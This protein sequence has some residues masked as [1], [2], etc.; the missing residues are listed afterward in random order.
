MHIIKHLENATKPI[1]SYEIVPPLRGTT[2]IDAI[3]N[4]IEQVLPYDPKWINVTTHASSLLYVE[5]NDGTITKRV[6][7]KRPGTTGICGVIQNKYGIDAVAHMLCQGFSQ[8]ETEDA[9]IELNYM[10]I[11]NVL[12]LKGDNLNYK[13]I[14]NDHETINH[15]AIDLVSQIRDIRDGRFL[16]DTEYDPINF[17]TGVAGYPEKHFESA[18]ME[19]NI[20]YLK[21]KID[22]GADY[23]VT[24][25]FFDNNKYFNFVKQCRE[26]GINVPIIPG[27][28]VLKS[29]NQ[30]NTIP[31]MFYVDLPQTLVADLST[32]PQKAAEIG[33]KWAMHQVG[34]LL[35]FGVPCVH[36]FLMND[37]GSV[38]EIVKEYQ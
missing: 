29:A 6:H 3:F 21:Q 19:L 36:F 5:K 2:S 15:H 4:I 7:K 8:Q 27:I 11:D 12:A 9:L 18:N 23:I 17:C 38:L 16:G 37:I 34:E 14:I 1:F 22:A 31:K 26:A 20:E 24:Q 13:R 28:K 32:N 10:G 33:K 25:M 30:L 35:D